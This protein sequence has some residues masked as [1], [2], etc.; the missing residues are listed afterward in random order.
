MGTVSVACK[1]PHGLVLRTFLMTKRYEPVMGGGTREVEEATQVGHSITIKG[2]AAPF[3]KSPDAQVAGGYALTT[4]VD[5]DIWDAWLAQ[6]ADHPA[7][8]AGL[9]FAAERVDYAKKQAEEQAS[10]K[11][12]ME[13]IDPSGDA[14]I[15][16]ITKAD[17]KAA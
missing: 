5:A 17:A 8:K 11:N 10:V 12:G 13:P 1:L 9:I 16:G 3:G 2:Y 15:R 7:V 6:N 14:R 4:G